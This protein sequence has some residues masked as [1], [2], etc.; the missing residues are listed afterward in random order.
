MY[1]GA[2]IPW[3]EF[4]NYWDITPWRLVLLGITVMLARRLPWVLLAVRISLVGSD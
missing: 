3:N 4:G 2:V 1:I